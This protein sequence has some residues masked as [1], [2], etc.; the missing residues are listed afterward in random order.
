VIGE[1]PGDTAR[2]QG[3]D[4]LSDAIAEP[5]S[6]VS[7][8]W[9]DRLGVRRSA[10]KYDGS[11]QSEA[12]ERG[13]VMHRLMEMVR[14]RTD[15]PSVVRRAMAS[16]LITASEGTEVLEMLYEVT[17]H[18][19]L[20]PYFQDK[21]LVRTEAEIMLPGGQVVRPDRVVFL[22]DQAVVIDYKT[23]R[24]AESHERQVMEY[25]DV[26]RGMGTARVH[27]MLVYLPDI[28]IIEL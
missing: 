27:G 18:P 12:Q 22:D 7:W 20:A 4:Q 25:M 11:E 13:L 17:D 6:M 14:Y 10:A 8:R 28:R 16:G 24:M 21:A 26:L 19:R 5:F 9:T 1:L 15:V 2:V 3:S 23:G